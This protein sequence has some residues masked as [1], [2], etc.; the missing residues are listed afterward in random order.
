MRL[1]TPL[2][3]SEL[4]EVLRRRCALIVHFSHIA[5]E[6]ARLLFPDDLRTAMQIVAGEELSCSVVWPQRCA[7]VGSVGVVLRPRTLESVT[8]A[9]AGD[10]GTI[11]DSRTSKREGLGEALGRETLTATLEPTTSDYNEWT[12]KDAD[13]VGIF[14]D[15]ASK[16]EVAM[17]VDPKTVDGYDPSIVH[18]GQIVG[19]CKIG[20]KEVFDAF[21][22]QPIFGFQDGEIVNLRLPKGAAVN[23]EDIYPV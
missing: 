2:R 23:P 9:S 16:L 22:D 1:T 5:K 21:P 6:G 8:S 12:V 15:L 18:V 20:L 14:V 13:V 17:E 19:A 10:A 7:A 3:L 4:A 11:V